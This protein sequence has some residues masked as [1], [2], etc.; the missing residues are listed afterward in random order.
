M[1]KILKKESVQEK[2]EKGILG[3][4][5]T[6]GS[7]YGVVYE[8]KR[9]DFRFPQSIE[10]FQYMAQD[11]TIAASNN[12]LDVMI[13]KIDWSFGVPDNATGK[14]KEAARF[15]NYCMNNMEHSWKSFIEEVGSY[16]IYGFHVAEKVWK[17]ITSEESKKFAGKMGWRKL[18]TRSQ[19]TIK[20][21]KFDDNVRDLLAIKQSITDISNIYDIETDDSGLIDLPIS[22][23]LLFSYKKRRGN[24]E[25]HS[26]LKDCYQPWS[27]KKTIESY[28]AVGRAKSLGGV[29]VMGIDASW[30]AKAQ[31]DPNSSEAT[32]LA[33]LQTNMENLHAGES[34]YMIVPLA[35]TDSGKPLFDFKLQGIEGGTTQD[36]TRDII[37]GKQLEIMMVY[38]TDVLKLGNESHGSFALAENKNN[39]LALGIQHHLGFI[40]DIIQEQLVPQTLKVNGFDLPKEQYPVLTHTDLDEENIDQL[41]KLIQRLASVNMLPRTKQTV[42]EILNRAGFKYE[43]T[44]GDVE[45]NDTFTANTLPK[46]IFGEEN[47]SGAGE[48]MESG[49]PNGTGDSNK[50]NSATN[51]DNKS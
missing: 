10:T 44:D 42:N 2:V 17:E 38:L 31:E 29:P 22:K 37:V 40:I 15:L 35:Y 11:S 16:R 14:Q 50:N 12:I 4:K 39:L 19:S 45:K 20:G 26:L 48:G 18:P 33:T 34:L 25:G 1:A 41:G 28:E 6:S 7:D 3:L 21:W 27:Y 5:F 9:A 23:S 30:L 43:L 36:N 24:P 47:E 49:N 8:D 46:E 13:G 32:V 51:M